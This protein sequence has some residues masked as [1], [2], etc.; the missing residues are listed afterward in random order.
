MIIIPL[1][2]PSL[3][4]LIVLL[5]TYLGQSKHNNGIL[6][7][8]TLPKKAL[9]HPKIKELQAA[10][11]K[12][13]WIYAGIIIILFIP[14]IFLGKLFAFQFIYFFVWT[15]LL[16]T[17]MT[18][19]FRRTF[20]IVMKLKRDNDWFVGEKRV[21]HADIKLSQMKQAMSVSV[22]W[23]AIPLL[24]SIVPITL[25][26]I[27]DDSL[28]RNTGIASL[29]MT[30]VMIGI[31]KAFEQSKAKVYSKN[32]NINIAINRTSRRYWSILWLGLSIF[33]SLNAHI[34]YFLLTS[35]MEITLAAWIGD[36]VFVSF[37]PLAAIIYVHLKIK[38]MESSTLESD[39]DVIYTDDD[40]YWANG[41]TYHNPNDKSIMVPKRVG[42]GTTINT[43]TSA[44]KSLMYGIVILVAA[45]LIGISFMMVRAEY[46]SPEIHIREDGVV[47][48]DYP[49]YKFKFNVDEVEEISLADTVP[50]GF[51]SN[52]EATNK[53]ARGNFKLDEYGKTKLYIFK[54]NP[55][56]IVIKLKDIYV[57]YNEKDVANT[58]ELYEEL[59]TLV[60]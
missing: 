19:P 15:A 7:G 9:E 23:Y 35:K 28:L 34:A 31:A 37:I 51:K 38:S 50:S 6:F 8:V 29:A 16:I 47:S 1:L 52:G 45:M 59:S 39:G 18:L 56:Y 22:Y 25:S 41:I 21:V 5:F 10:Y 33:E 11:R 30:L 55:P 24:L 48:I 14:V 58:R 13:Y 42:I 17:L 54:Q 53:Y 32:S 4:L 2:I 49:M 26:F 12:T 36:I 27:L 44:G 20:R 60:K 43:G 57:I 46:T 3:I 40:E